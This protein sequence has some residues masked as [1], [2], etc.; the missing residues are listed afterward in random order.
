MA[1]AWNNKIF[2]QIDKQTTEASKNSLRREAHALTQKITG[3]GKVF[4]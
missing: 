3:N 2:K 4:K 1:K